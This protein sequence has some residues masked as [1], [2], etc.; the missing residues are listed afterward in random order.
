MGVAEN[1]PP[2]GIGILFAHYQGKLI[3]Y[4]L[5]LNTPEAEIPP[6][7]SEGQE[8][9]Q[10]ALE[11][12]MHTS[13]IFIQDAM[14]ALV[15]LNRPAPVDIAGIFLICLAIFDTRSFFTINSLH[16]Y[17]TENNKEE[18]D[19]LQNFSRFYHNLIQRVILIMN[20]AGNPLG[21]KQ[22]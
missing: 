10:Q 12:I 17:R 2:G 18:A 4:F 9:R 21:F 20:T 3:R 16:H 7:S 22:Y 1:P 6:D 8:K 15:Q 11:A 13:L 19:W 14:E 5:Q